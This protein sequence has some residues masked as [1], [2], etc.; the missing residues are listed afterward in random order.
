MNR[1]QSKTSILVLVI[2][3]VSFCFLPAPA[4]VAIK[5]E[6]GASS[7][8]V[9]EGFVYTLTVNGA[10]QVEEPETPIHSDFFVNALETKIQEHDGSRTFIYRYRV[11]PRHGGLLNLPS[12]A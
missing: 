1:E 8:F 7:F 4:E 11:I 5:T 10:E 6:I 2:A 12:L 3:T 9:G